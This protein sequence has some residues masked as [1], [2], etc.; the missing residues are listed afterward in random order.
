[1]NGD[2]TFAIFSESGEADVF[3][4]L[5]ASGVKSAIIGLKVGIGLACINWIT[6]AVTFIL[7][8]MC[9]FM[10]VFAPTSVLVYRAC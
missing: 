3:Q 1:M 8:S 2:S 9:Y 5:V 10:R 6:F 4:Y 7:A